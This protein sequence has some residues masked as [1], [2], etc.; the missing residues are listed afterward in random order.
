MVL[1]ALTMR[2]ESD[3]QSLQANLYMQLGTGQLEDAMKSLKAL[4]TDVPYSNKKL[5]SMDMA[6]RYR[7]IIST[8]LNAIGMRVDV[9]H[10]LATGRIDI[11]AS[12]S[13]YIYVIELKNNGGKDAAIK[14]ILANQYLEPFKADKREVIGLGIELDDEGKGLLDWAKA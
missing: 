10:M 3:I 12:T 5:A 8:I 2:E 14:Q 9:E 11:L 6:E 7:L 13:R 1:P 4:I